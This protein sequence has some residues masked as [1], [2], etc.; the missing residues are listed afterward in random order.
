VSDLASKKNDTP[1]GASVTNL[2][3]RDRSLVIARRSRWPVVAVGMFA[4]AALAIVVF[5][6]MRRTEVIAE[7]PVPDAPPA[8]DPPV[9]REVA[10]PSDAAVAVVVDAAPLVT[11][12]P[13]P[14]RP[15]PKAPVSDANNANNADNAAPGSF[16]IGSKPFAR[17][18]IDGGYVGDTP[19]FRHVLKPG[20]HTVRAVLEDGR[21]KTF[22]I[23]VVAEQELNSGTLAW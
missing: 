22:A 5:L 10:A 14:T 1:A 20:P 11:K 21:S 17:I 9:P 16:T 3:L 7:K 6:A 2:G 15:E 4:A 8:T 23:K 19:L 18:Y 12:R 13:S